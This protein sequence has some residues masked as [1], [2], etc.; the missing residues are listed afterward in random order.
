MHYFSIMYKK[1]IITLMAACITI[2][3]HAQTV[4][5]TLESW[6]TGNVGF[7]AVQLDFVDGWRC[8]DSLAHAY[9]FVLGGTPERQLFKSTDKHG[10]TYAARVVTKEQGMLGNVAG[11]LTNAVINL[12]IVNQDFTLTGGTPIYGRVYYVN[13]WVKYNPQGGDSAFVAVSALKVGAGAG[14]A[15]SILGEGVHTITAASL[16]RSSMYLSL[17]KLRH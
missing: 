9:G 8:P 2:S 15:D 4:F 7:P 17:M 10:G 1:L 16:T 6:K 14:G 5:S 3:I 12:D 11:V 13:A